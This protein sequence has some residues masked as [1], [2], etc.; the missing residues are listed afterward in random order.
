[1]LGANE[2]D[3]RSWGWTEEARVGELRLDPDAF[4][5][6]EE[7]QK[8]ENLGRLIVTNTLGIANGVDVSRPDVDAKAQAV[9]N[10][11]YTFGGR[12][13]AIWRVRPDSL[14]LVHDTGSQMEETI[15][16]V[17]PHFFN[18]DGPTIDKGETRSPAKGPEPEGMALGKIDGRTYAF[19]GLERVGGIMVYDVT[20]P[21]QTRFVEYLNTRTKLVGE[22]SESELT[23]S[24]IGPE[25]LCFVPSSVSPDAKGRPLL[26]VGN[27]VSG[28]TSIFVIE[29]VS[30]GNER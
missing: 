2:G 14:E 22:A 7:L 29:T 27:E 5:N 6:A 8:P 23:Q 19:V 28:T 3:G 16:E 9:Y 21:Q 30:V 4:P 1:L 20:T 10:S 25:G 18:S 13:L 12:S 17:T 26:L 15:A 24:D 11:L